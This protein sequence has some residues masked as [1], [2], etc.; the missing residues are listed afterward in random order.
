MSLFFE[1]HHNRIFIAKPVQILAQAIHYTVQVTAVKKPVPA[2]RLNLLALSRIVLCCL[3]W[4]K[5]LGEV[6]R[7]VGRYGGGRKKDRARGIYAT[8]PIRYGSRS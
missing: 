2:L 5:G 1:T 6:S 7:E 4:K 3:W 8:R